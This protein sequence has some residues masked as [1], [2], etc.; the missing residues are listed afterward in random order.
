MTTNTRTR[1]LGN[2]PMTDDQ[3]TYLIRLA[4]E[5]PDWQDHL[6]G[7]VYERTFDVVTGSGKFTSRSEASAAIHA[8]AALPAT[9][10]SRRPLPEMFRPQPK[11]PRPERVVVWH[12]SR[13]GQRTIGVEQKGK[14]FHVRVRVAATDRP[15][16]HLHKE[17][18]SES[19]AR[20]YANRLWA[21][22]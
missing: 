11:Q 10:R 6:D 16:G 15:L 13:D 20:T 14:K 8:L 19:G 4:D 12:P 21:G 22:E 2:L 18:T 7:H 9:R 5:R 3:R 1:I 17:F